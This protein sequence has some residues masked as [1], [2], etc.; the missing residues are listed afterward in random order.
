MSEPRRHSILRWRDLPDPDRL[1]KWEYKTYIQSEAWT[2]RKRAYRK[3][4]LPRCEACGTEGRTHIHH[5]TYARL[6]KE[7][8]SDL[9]ELCATCHLTVHEVHR[10]LHAQ[11]VQATIAR[12]TKYFLKK[13][14][15]YQ[16]FI[17]ATT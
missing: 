9:V 6:G 17:S 2:E 13:T 15:R 7:P 1:P 10:W 16:E 8:N 14:P 4:R 11:G 5:R 3:G 12:P